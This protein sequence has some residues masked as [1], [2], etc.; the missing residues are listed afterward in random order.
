MVLP[1][2]TLRH[3]FHFLGLHMNR[4]QNAITIIGVCFSHLFEKLHVNV[5]FIFVNFNGHTLNQSFSP[6]QCF[7][8]SEFKTMLLTQ[9]TYKKYAYIY[10]RRVYIK[11]HIPIYKL[12]SIIAQ[13]L[14]LQSQLTRMHNSIVFC[15][16]LR[17][18]QPVGMYRDFR[19]FL[20][21]IN[22]VRRM[23]Y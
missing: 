17:H 11:F 3:I 2:N 9:T 15:A 6:T 23:M 1:F 18:G 14:Y 8:I 22:S 5:H 19:N 16:M 13:Y 12:L 20:K 7:V 4:L 21:N 10:I